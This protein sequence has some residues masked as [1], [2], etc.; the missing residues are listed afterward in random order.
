MKCPFSGSYV[1]LP[2]P[3]RGDAVDLESFRALIDFHV[4]R[5][6]DGLVAV[7]TSGEAAT[8]SDYE[9]RSVIEAAVEH[10]AGR[11]PVI[12]GVGTNSTRVTLELARF[13]EKAGADGAL[14]V[15]PYYN[16][17]TPK[18]LLG[19]YGA[20]AEACAL[21]IVLYNV[22]SRT[23]CDLKPAT[24]AELRRRHA[25]VVAIKEAS[26]SVGRARELLA[27]SDIALIA[28][29]DGLIAELMSLGAAGVI[30]VVANIAPSEVAELCRVARPGG[31]AARTA[32][33]V[34]WLSPLVRDLFIESNPIPMKAA[35]AAMGLCSE[36]V[37]LP[38][39]TLE[40][41]SRERLLA[42]LHEAGLV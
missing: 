24:V 3:F 16:K 22:P 14:A 6:S 35:L 21:P 15:T 39:A 37:R 36:E 18:G 28:G 9:R 13:A 12:A 38:L 27:I 29:E 40:D 20:L 7:G 10:S 4:E 1:A 19:H 33:L 23:G 25:N 42:T 2:T 30:G 8:L 34:A 17:P 11:L 5:R 32:E 41:A 26:N 31:D